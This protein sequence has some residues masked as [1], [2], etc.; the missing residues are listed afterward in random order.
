MN[1]TRGYNSPGCHSTLATTRRGLSQVP[2]LITEAGMIPAH[3]LGRPADGAL[4][5]MSD[6]LL[7]HLVGGQPDGV[8]HAFGFEVVVDLR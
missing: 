5:E 2:G 4:Q 7:Q 3:V 1:P 6:A 8:E